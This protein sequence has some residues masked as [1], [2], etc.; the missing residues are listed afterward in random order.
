MAIYNLYVL[1]LVDNIFVTKNCDTGLVDSV[2][3]HAMLHG[4][5]QNLVS[6]MVLSA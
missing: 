5:D 6:C 2:S 3:I 4:I 1:L